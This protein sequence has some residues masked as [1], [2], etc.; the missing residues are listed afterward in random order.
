MTQSKKV[1]KIN[2]EGMIVEEID[3][4]DAVDFDD[5]NPKESHDSIMFN[6]REQGIPL[7]PRP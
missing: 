1:F 2:I 3:V 6:L 7:Q 5:V 4:T